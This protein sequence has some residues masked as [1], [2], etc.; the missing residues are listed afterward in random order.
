MVYNVCQAEHEFPLASFRQAHTMTSREISSLVA[1]AEADYQYWS[2]IDDEANA[3]DVN[4]TVAF[5]ARFFEG[6]SNGLNAVHRYHHAEEFV[7]RFL[8][9][10]HIFSLRDE[11]FGPVAEEL[12][13]E[14]LV[15]GYSPVAQPN[16]DVIAERLR[17]K[18]R[19]WYYL[20]GHL[21][22]SSFKRHRRLVSDILAYDL[23]STFHP[24]A[25]DTALLDAYTSQFAPEHDAFGTVDAIGRALGFSEGHRWCLWFNTAFADGWDAVE[26]PSTLA[27]EKG[28][29][30]KILDTVRKRRSLKPDS[31][32]VAEAARKLAGAYKHEISH[33]RIYEEG[34]DAIEPLL[35]EYVAVLSDEMVAK[36]SV[37]I[38][39]ALKRIP[40]HP[41]LT[42][43]EES[44][45]MYLAEKL[46]RW[47]ELLS[48]ENADIA[49]TIAVHEILR[50]FHPHEMDGKIVATARDFSASSEGILTVIGGRS[51]K[52]SDK[53]IAHLLFS[54]A[55][56]GWPD[57]LDIARGADLS[58]RFLAA[59]ERVRSVFST[60]SRLPKNRYAAMTKGF[61]SFYTIKKI[62]EVYYERKGAL[63]N[64]NE[65]LDVLFS[66]LFRNKDA[67][68]TDEQA[69]KIESLM[70]RT[71]KRL[72]EEQ[73]DEALYLLAAR[74]II[75]GD[76]KDLGALLDD[77]ESR[78]RF[79]KLVFHRFDA[80]TFNRIM[81]TNYAG[82]ANLFG[83]KGFIILI[84]AYLVGSG[85]E[86]II[87]HF[88]EG[89]VAT[90]L[91]A[92]NLSA[93]ALLTTDPLDS[94][95]LVSPRFDTLFDTAFDL[96]PG[97]FA[98]GWAMMD[99]GRTFLS[100][101]IPIGLM[102]LITSYNYAF[103][104]M[105]RIG[106]REK[107]FRRLAS[108]TKRWVEGKPHLVNLTRRK[109][110]SVFFEF[111]K[112]GLLV[113]ETTFI[114][115]TLYGWGFHPTQLA[116]FFFLL[117]TIC[118]SA[119][120]GN[121]LK[122]E[123]TLGTSETISDTVRDFVFLPI[124]ELGKFLGGQV[125]S[126]NFIPWLVKTG[127]EPLYKSVTGVMHSFI[128]F[129]R[130]RKEELV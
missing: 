122:D 53:F 17:L 81:A 107:S 4:T 75:A 103:Y 92:I 118:L 123:V 127:V 65:R 34:C 82:L 59:L 37:E 78:E 97:A 119:Y 39:S 128:A 55:L 91:N 10:K 1:A 13:I 38:L 93:A 14:M 69:E 23:T 61:T 104:K 35:T 117:S 125:R 57:A 129:Q 43:D 87:N 6:V 112:I 50:V 121:K 26:D 46:K 47:R 73:F 36:L 79:Q 74:K 67:G 86:H 111:F 5:Y 116:L 49:T 71:P 52:F 11:E 19:R 3:P 130:E 33:V 68:S 16:L 106:H 102:F 72:S 88:V 9:R 27:R 15:S 100:L 66:A 89:S 110:Y 54:R 115:A 44:L 101:A 8:E 124:V 109:Q 108:S 95:P 30:A 62:I 24:S 20:L 51:L 63:G 84:E 48:K 60:V 41:A 96:S 113:L 56:P 70:L 12:A 77:A 31:S 80:Y 7:S 98:S 85:L 29:F 45:R 105:N 40:N 120:Q 114:I 76:H 22:G 58:P 64:V 18:F 83:T 126:V 21:S 32:P 28:R 25:L 2:S 94:M 42:F 90:F 99:W